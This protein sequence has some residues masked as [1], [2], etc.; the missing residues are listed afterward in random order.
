MHYGMLKKSIL[1]LACYLP[2]FSFA[3]QQQ[4]KPNIL[5]VLC[6]DLGVGDIGVFYQNKLKILSQKGVPYQLTPNIDAIGSNGAKLTHNYTNA[7]VCAPSRASLISGMNQGSANVRDNQFDKAIEDNYNM[8]NTLKAVGYKTAIVGKWGL[9]GTT[10]DWPA[11]P[12]NR[13]F[14]YFFGYM[15]HSDGHEHYPKEGIYRGSKEVWENHSELS[16]QLDKCY[17]TDLWTAAAKKWIV[18]E[19]QTKAPFFLYLA[20]D[21]PHAVLELPT[22]AYPRGG[23]LKGGMQWTGKSGA[24][25]STAN[26]KVDSWTQP[27]YV[28]ATY[29]DDKNPTTPEVPW[30]DT[31]KRYATATGRIDAAVGDIIQLLKDLDI[32]DNTMVVFSS[33][34]GPSI[35][36]YLPNGYA[37]NSP[38]FFKSYGPFDGIKRDCWEGGIRMPTLVQWPGKIKTGIDVN[39]PCV[40]SDWNA[41]F[42]DAAGFSVPARSSG[43][44][45]LPALTK[46]GKQAPSN[47]YVEYAVAGETP[48][49][50]DFE[51]R[52]RGLKRG[53]M[54]AIRI[55]NYMGVRY[56]IK[57]ANTDFEIYDVV[58]DPKETKNLASQKNM[59]KLQ[60]QMK[61]KALQSRLPDAEAK[62]PYDLALV[63]SVSTKKL[64]KG[65]KW[66]TFANNAKWL[67]KIYGDGKAIKNG[68][69]KNLSELPQ[70]K[71]I[72][73]V[74]GYV[75]VKVDGEYT[76]SLT[77]PLRSNFKLHNVTLLDADYHYES[78]KTVSNN[79]RLKK[80]LHPFSFTFLRTDRLDEV[81]LQ[82]ATG[83][84]TAKA[85]PASAFAY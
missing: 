33:D 21:C 23:G 73:F 62:R 20:Y 47:V 2:L 32:Y 78:G 57:D 34:N 14:D 48:N 12:L 63:P 52:R 66:Q 65:I 56:Q 64:K 49:F 5:F 37:P 11:H 13:G 22:Q 6:D 79:I 82:W 83:G 15:R 10:K 3:Q 17:T 31:Y 54:Q 7:P 45:L 60:Q 74:S 80:G 28:N 61:D 76:F 50:E 35:E 59:A 29:D 44:S 27:E 55:G 77:G 9:Q 70:D 81:K 1:L 42:L 85:I 24:M 46:K 40:F 53:Q 18:N 26:G 58:K 41:T 43:V 68:V 69:A 75:D 72:I 19:Q 39:E 25:I 8:A 51:E 16:Q 67:P 4:Q 30:P 36:S 38:T 84:Q 71:N